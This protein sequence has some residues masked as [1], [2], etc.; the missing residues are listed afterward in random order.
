MHGRNVPYGSQYQ[1]IMAQSLAHPFWG[2][3]RPGNCNS[4]CMLAGKK[5]WPLEILTFLT[6]TLPAVSVHELPEHQPYLRSAY[7]LP[8]QTVPRKNGRM[9]PSW[10]TYT[11]RSMWHAACMQP[12]CCCE[13]RLAFQLSVRCTMY[14]IFCVCAGNNEAW[15]ASPINRHCYVA[16]SCGFKGS[17][18]SLGMGIAMHLQRAFGFPKMG[19]RI[20]PMAPEIF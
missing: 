10:R 9:V 2:E 11:V 14:H 3:K 4:Q 1:C 5:P 6:Y 8:H 18:V 20:C 15:G 19:I 16:L 7:I 12:P 17:L 13:P